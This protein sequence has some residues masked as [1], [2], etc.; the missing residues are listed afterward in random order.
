MKKVKICLMGF[1]NVSRAF[2]R[3]AEHKRAELV[4]DYGVSLSFCAVATGRH[5]RAINPDG[6]DMARALALAEASQPLDTLSTQKTPA[7]PSAFIAASGSDFLLENTPVNY[8]SGQPAVDHIRAAL[9][10]GGDLREHLRAHLISGEINAL[11][12]RTR[13]ILRQPVY[14]QPNPR[15]RPYPWPLV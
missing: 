4:K 2:V 13:N 8:E 11:A 15:R 7:D 14:P 5:G 1:G 10:N 3:L 9:E 12:A 6:L